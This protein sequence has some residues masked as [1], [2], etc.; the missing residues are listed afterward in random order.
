MNRI[1]TIA[2]LA[3]VSAAAFATMSPLAGGGRDLTK[4]PL[5]PGVREKELGAKSVTLAKAIEMAAKEGGV[6]AS[7]AYDDGGQIAI[8]LFQGGAEHVVVMDSGSG[9]VISKT[10]MARFPGDAVSGEGHTSSTGLIVYELKTGEGAEAIAK[11]SKVSVHYTGWLVDGTKF[12]SSVDRKQPFQFSL[13]GGVIAG[14][15]E[16]VAG[17][18]VGGKRKLVIPA[19]LGYGD[20]GAG[21][22]IPPKAVLVFDVELLSIN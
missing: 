12:D 1:L 14:W 21:A 19:N 10:A 2:A 15:L 22:V 9:A 13:G 18:K 8:S 5:D 7:A 6:V 3:L 11:T 16:G 20:R 4:I 17:M